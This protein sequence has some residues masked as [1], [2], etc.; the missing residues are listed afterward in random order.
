MSVHQVDNHIM[1]NWNYSIYTVIHWHLLQLSDKYT[2]IAFT[3]VEAYH[4]MTCYLV[5]KSNLLICKLDK[6]NTFIYVA[7]FLPNSCFESC[8]YSLLVMCFKL[9]IWNTIHSNIQ[10]LVQIKHKLSK[11]VLVHELLGLRTHM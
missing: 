11:N 8:T 9:I 10:K 4:Y 3:S 2:I 5:I 7:L 6:V 1:E